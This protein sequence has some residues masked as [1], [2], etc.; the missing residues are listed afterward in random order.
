[1]NLIYEIR[2]ASG[3]SQTAFAQRLNVSQSAV[4]QYE[5]GDIVPD[6]K[7][8]MK[9]VAI[10]RQFRVKARVEDICLRSEL[11]KEPANV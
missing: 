9:I 6:I 1:M 10:G 5:R 11:A 2:K 4:S 8:G 3:M 7:R